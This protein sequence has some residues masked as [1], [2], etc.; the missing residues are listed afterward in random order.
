MN[1]HHDDGGSPQSSW[2][3]HDSTRRRHKLTLRGKVRSRLR[4]WFTGQDFLEVET[5]TLQVS[6]GWEAHIQSF[7]TMMETG[8][9]E[10]R[11]Y[12]RTSPEIAMKKLLA[13]GET[14][15]YQ[16]CQAYRNGESSPLHQPEFTILEWY[17]T[18]QSDQQALDAIINDCQSLIRYCADPDHLKIIRNHHSCDIASVWRRLTVAEAFKTYAGVDILAGLSNQGGADRDHLAQEALTANVSVATDDAWDDIFHKIF[19][20]HVQPHLGINQ[21]DILTNYPA[22]LAALAALSPDDPRQSQRFEI[23]IHGIEL[24]N[25]CVELRDLQEH[26]HRYQREQS[27]R[28]S[29]YGQELPEDIGFM[30]II[31]NGLPPCAGVALGFD[32]LVLLFSGAEDIREVLWEALT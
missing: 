18:N 13:A 1:K 15:I 30:K 12:L 3:P 17:R 5:P 6:P 9:S 23:F 22:P 8:G 19:Y 2:H 29:R 27:I 20:A 26:K 10:A 24:A 25:G 31:E 11:R 4:A 21:P 14:R 7:S 16:L 28:Q 32:R